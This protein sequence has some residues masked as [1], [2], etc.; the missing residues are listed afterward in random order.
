LSSYIPNSA[1]YEKLPA[2]ARTPKKLQKFYQVTLQQLGSQPIIASTKAK[3]QVLSIK[4]P[5]LYTDELRRL[6]ILAGGV[7]L[8]ILYA[9]R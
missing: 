5:A 2:I 1:V 4:A 7:L 3:G 9:L 6:D 8:W